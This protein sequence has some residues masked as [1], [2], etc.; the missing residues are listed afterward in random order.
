MSALF[1]SGRAERHVEACCEVAPEETGEATDGAA[2]F[3]VVSVN[4]R[5]GSNSASPT[6]TPI[7]SS[8]V[9]TQVIGERAIVRT[10]IILLLR[11]S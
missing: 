5:H 9:S 7:T 11:I 4:N 3:T 6:P 8:P 10:D 2:S 1:E